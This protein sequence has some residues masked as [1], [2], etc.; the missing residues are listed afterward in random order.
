MNECVSLQ[1]Q[2]SNTDNAYC[3]DRHTRVPH[4]SG[5]DDD[6]R[7]KTDGREKEERVDCVVRSSI[8]AGI[9]T[10]LC[11]PSACSPLFI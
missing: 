10:Y 9:T 11:W 7:P 4:G 3:I 6:N 5:C 1:F 8:N 2:Y